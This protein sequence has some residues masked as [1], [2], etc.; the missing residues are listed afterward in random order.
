MK[1]RFKNKKQI[2]AWDTLK[3]K[4]IKNMYEDSVWSYTA[5]YTLKKYR[6]KHKN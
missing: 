1:V 2:R 5:V 4:D 3:R 6:L